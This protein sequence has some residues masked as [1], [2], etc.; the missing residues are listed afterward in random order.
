MQGNQLVELPQQF[1]NLI[2]LLNLEMDDNELE[3]K[4]TRTI[5]EK[6]YDTLHGNIKSLEEN[7]AQKIFKLSWKEL[8]DRQR[9]DYEKI[10]YAEEIWKNGPHQFQFRN[11]PLWILKE[12]I[13]VQ[14]HPIEQYEF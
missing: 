13:S 1:I 5:K 6:K 3:Q 2:N 9:G 7:S 14:I 8:T 4:D 12:K 10:G 11:H